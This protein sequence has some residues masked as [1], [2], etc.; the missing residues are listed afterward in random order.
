MIQGSFLCLDSCVGTLRPLLAR[1]C[2]VGP[3]RV[4]VLQN[5]VRLEC[6]LLPS[7][8]TAVHSKMHSSTPTTS[9][10]PFYGSYTETDPAVISQQGVERFKQEKR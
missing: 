2:T 3:G 9:Q 5:N 6:M 7:W 4:T 10:I 8:S 1:I